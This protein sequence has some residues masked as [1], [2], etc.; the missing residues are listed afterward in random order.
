MVELQYIGVVVC[1]NFGV[2]SCDVGE[3]QCGGAVM[4]GKFQGERIAVWKSCNVEGLRSRG[5][6]F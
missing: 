1:G 4:W 2:G 5:V 6:A 3:L